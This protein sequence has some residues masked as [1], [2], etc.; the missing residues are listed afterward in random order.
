MTKIWEYPEE[1]RLIWEEPIEDDGWGEFRTEDERASIVILGMAEFVI[2]YHC[3]LGPTLDV[4]KHIA[5]LVKKHDCPVGKE[6]DIFRCP[7]PEADNE[8]EKDDHTSC[9]VFVTEGYLQQGE[10]T[11]CLPS[12]KEKT[13]ELLERYK[14]LEGK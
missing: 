8:I 7:C 13:R 14:E 9:G 1:L 10:H 3:L 11:D 12:C 2:Y 6:R 5:T 4:D